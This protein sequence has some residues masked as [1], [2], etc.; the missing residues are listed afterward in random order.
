[1]NFFLIFC[2]D[3]CPCTAKTVQKWRCNNVNYL[4][5]SLAPLNFIYMVFSIYKSVVG[6]RLASVAC[7]I[8]SLICWYC[9]KCEWLGLLDCFRVCLQPYKAF[10]NRCKMHIWLKMV[11]QLETFS[12]RDMCLL[13]D[14]GIQ[15]KNQWQSWKPIWFHLVFLWVVY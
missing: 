11:K 4:D 7:S 13:F 5:N 8:C 9:C 12:C 10:S 2:D 14:C 1:M 15:T 3:V 6:L